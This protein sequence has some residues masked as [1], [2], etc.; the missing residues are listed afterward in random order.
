M[1]TGLYAI[2]YM[3]KHRQKKVDRRMKCD[4]FAG[5]VVSGIKILLS[6][7]TVGRDLKGKELTG[8]PSRCFQ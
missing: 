5:F 7:N 8:V 2:T 4:D 1:E 6:V 3:C